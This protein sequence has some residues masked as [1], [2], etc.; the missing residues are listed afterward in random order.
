MH[1]IVNAVR[2]ILFTWVLGAADEACSVKS[3]PPFSYSGD[4]IVQDCQVPIS[5]RLSSEVIDLFR[6]FA[7]DTLVFPNY[8]E[9]HYLLSQLKIRVIDRRIPGAVVELGCR[10][11]KTSVGIRRLINYFDRNRSF[12]VYDSFEGLPDRTIED[13]PCVLATD[14]KGGMV[15][16]EADF[17]DTFESR[18]LKLPHGIHK[19]FFADVS[20]DDYPSLVAFAYFD[21]DLYTSILDSFRKVYHKVVPGGVIVV[22]DYMTDGRFLGPKQAID[23]F[24]ADKPDKIEECCGLM[25]LIVKSR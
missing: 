24:L 23:E 8:G 22:H 18:G 19:G 2:I 7:A 14:S 10:S 12:H 11:G 17:R 21:S 13:G 1:C 3:E 9:R 16:S 5:R 15:V 6:R 25:A 4:V 20:D